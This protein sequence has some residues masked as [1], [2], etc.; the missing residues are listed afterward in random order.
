[1]KL[2]AAILSG[3]CTAMRP[4]VLAFLEPENFGFIALRVPSK[5]NVVKNLSIRYSRVRHFSSYFH[6]VLYA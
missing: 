3:I 5:R 2:H 4:I 1:M 6:I